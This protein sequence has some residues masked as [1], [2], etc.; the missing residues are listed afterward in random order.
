MFPLFEATVFPDKRSGINNSTPFVLVIYS[1]VV[2][3]RAWSA[4]DLVYHQVLTIERLNPA[5]PAAYQTDLCWHGM[6]RGFE[7]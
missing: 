6:S 2:Q 1:S 4:V 3:L 7:L 5:V